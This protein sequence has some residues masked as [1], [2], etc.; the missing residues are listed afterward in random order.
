MPVRDFKS[1]LFG[2]IDAGNVDGTIVSLRRAWYVVAA[3]Q[4]A[5]QLLLMWLSKGFTPEDLLDPFICAIGGYSSAPERAGRWR[6]FCSST[7][8]PSAP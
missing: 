6:S 2:S 4:A 3:L 1:T 8:L 7:R 5:L